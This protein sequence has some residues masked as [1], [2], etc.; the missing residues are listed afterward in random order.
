MY[1]VAPDC[2]ALRE[3]AAAAVTCV[4]VSRVQWWLANRLVASGSESTTASG[5]VRRADHLTRIVLPPQGTEG[6]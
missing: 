5:R 2:I 6:S 4:D 3:A 1:A